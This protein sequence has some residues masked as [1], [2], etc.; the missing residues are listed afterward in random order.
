MRL[1]Q[2]VT[3]DSRQSQKIKLEDGSQVEVSLYFRP[4]QTGWFLDLKY[5][6]FQVYN[7]RVTASLNF[8]RQF[9]NKL[10]FGLACIVQ[11]DRDPMF[12]EDFASGFSSLYLLSEEEVQEY[13][14]YLSA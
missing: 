10:R 5:L 12:L 3:A 2:Q 9:K 6:D 4:M 8:I 13:E 14:D 1:I 7:L 11:G